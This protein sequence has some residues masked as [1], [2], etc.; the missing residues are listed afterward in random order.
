MIRKA[1]KNDIASI[2]KLGARLHSDYEHLNNLEQMFEKEYF[3]FF[4]VEVN[5]RV[6]GFLSV[7]EL[8]ETVDI[9]DLYVLPE[10]R[11]KHF[12]SSLLN[13][14][15]GDVSDTVELFTLEVATNNEKA[16]SLY[17]NFGFEIINKRLSY[18]GTQDAYLM[19]LRCKR[20]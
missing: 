17:Q 3:K 11:R 1:T 9:I 7:T 18:Y 16:I 13:Y 8:Y 5:R 10:C 4:V 14:M 19:G 12:A 6:V 15:I 20:T 2:Y